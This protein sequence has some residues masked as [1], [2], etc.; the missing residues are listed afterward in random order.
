[1]ELTKGVGA[2]LSKDTGAS[3]GEESAWGTRLTPWEA[4][5]VGR[6]PPTLESAAR[7]AH[8]SRLPVLK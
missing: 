2:Y 5:R 4:R 3:T 6:A 8:A 7:E 1:M